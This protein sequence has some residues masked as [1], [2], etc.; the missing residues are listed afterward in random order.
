MMN[1]QSS[2]RENRQIKISAFL[3]ALTAL[4]L[5]LSGCTLFQQPE[6]GNGS[7]ISVHAPGAVSRK[8]I[9]SRKEHKTFVCLIAEQDMPFSDWN[10][11]LGSWQ[12][13]EP[14]IVRQI[15]AKLNMNVV[16]VPVPAVALPSA[17]RN[18]RGDIAAGKLTTGQ[19]AASRMT[20]VVP[21]APAKTGK[22]ALMIRNDESI[23]KKD[24]T[25]AAEK[26]DGSA[27][28][29]ANTLEQKPVSV[30]V[31]EKEENDDAISISVDLK[32]KVPKGADKK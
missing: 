25:K 4:F 10:E 13:A 19:I 29:K 22:Y 12:G 31:V 17:L 30:E 15:A 11:E 28:V 18:G 9:Q 21:Y 8:R 6:K 3:A 7:G 27:L 20:A 1:A 26:I 23:W 2:S 5:P 32:S 24:L 14:E 16:F